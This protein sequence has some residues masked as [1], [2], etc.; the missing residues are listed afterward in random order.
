MRGKKPQRAKHPGLPGA[1]MVAKQGCLPVPITEPSSSQT[2]LLSRAGSPPG[3]VSV[4]WDVTGLRVMVGSI[5]PVRT[6]GSHQE[7]IQYFHR[8]RFGYF[9]VLGMEPSELCKCSATELY[10]PQTQC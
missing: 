3:D 6:L 8:W 7:M 9:V 4:T 10:Q 5:S 1:W 2:G